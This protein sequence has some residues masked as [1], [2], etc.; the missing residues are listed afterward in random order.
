ME[1]TLGL[2]RGLYGHQPE[3]VTGM[4]H[5]LLLSEAHLHVKGLVLVLEP[6]KNHLN[7]H[8]STLRTIVSV[9]KTLLFLVSSTP[10]VGKRFIV[11]VVQMH[12]GIIE[13]GAVAFTKQD[14]QH[15]RILFASKSASCL[16]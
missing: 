6:S 1:W 4:S 12:V 16:L 3:A 15:C 13:A 11:K 5:L 9:L 14:K 10:Y 8:Y 7:L 2:F